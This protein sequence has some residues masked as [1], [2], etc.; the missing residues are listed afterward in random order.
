MSAYLILEQTLNQRD[1]R[2]FDYV[3][4]EHGNKKPVLNKK[5][6]LSPRTGRSLS[7]RSFPNGFGKISTG[8]NG[9]AASTT[10]HSIPAVP[11]NTMAIISVS[12][13]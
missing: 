8:G 13:A 10:K 6:P 1:V 2:V 12:R 7:S 9:C 5:K 4:D 11:V 3:E